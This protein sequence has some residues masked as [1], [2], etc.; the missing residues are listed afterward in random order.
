MD[1][2]KQMMPDQLDSDELTRSPQMNAVIK[3]ANKVLEGTGELDLLDLRIHEVEMLIDQME[4][5]FKYESRFQEKTNVFLK[6][7]EV[8]EYNFER[9]RRYLD[10]MKKYFDSPKTR[11]IEEGL[12][13]CR[14]GFK[15]LFEAFDNLK[16]IE[17]KRKKYSKSPYLN[18]IY[19]VATAVLKGTLTVDTFRERIDGLIRFEENFFINFQNFQP[20]EDERLVFEENHD[21]IMENIQ[22]L[23][24]GLKQARVYLSDSNPDHIHN[25]LEKARKA[26]NY[27]AEFEQKLKE[28]REAPKVKYCFKCGAQ[29]PRTVKYC[30]KCNFNFPPLQMK[31]ESTIDVRLEEGG[32]KETGHVMTENL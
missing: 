15:R 17:E 7:S 26:A 16:A 19:R 25:G 27:M 12:K 5:F 22:N 4:Q 23:I 21:E 18:E 13:G 10:R 2:L 3:E 1:R 31:D 30:V 20:T 24:D 14:K 9:V 11:Y 28:A 29:N 32:I 6:E 8:I